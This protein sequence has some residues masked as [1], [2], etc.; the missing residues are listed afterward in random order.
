MTTEKQRQQI[1]NMMKGGMIKLALLEKI[2]TE[3]ANENPEMDLTDEALLEFI[4]NNKNDFEV[5][6]ERTLDVGNGKVIQLGAE[7]TQEEVA[8]E[9]FESTA[10]LQKRLRAMKTIDAMKYFMF[11]DDNG[12]EITMKNYPYAEQAEY[13]RKFVIAL[14]TRTPNTDAF[15][16]SVKDTPN[17]PQEDLDPLKFESLDDDDALLAEAKLRVLILENIKNL[18]D[19]LK[20]SL[21]TK[22]GETYIKPDDLMTLI[23]RAANI[24]N[25]IE[26]IM[27]QQ[28]TMKELLERQSSADAKNNRGNGLDGNTQLSANFHKN[29]SSSSADYVLRNKRLNGQNFSSTGTPGTH[30]ELAA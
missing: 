14:V 20:N 18:G 16:R 27:Q 10:L 11:E 29:V 6:D 4:L 24:R 9:S 23:H 26:T 3:I 12:E 5:P 28:Q 25:G 17:R 15:F 19:D 1:A 13:L 7:N 22:D 30:Y 8:A 2:L 21:V